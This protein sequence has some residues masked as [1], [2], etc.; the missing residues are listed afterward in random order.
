MTGS[1]LT[2]K[3]RLSQAIETYLSGESG[4]AL[5]NYGGETKSH[6]ETQG[7]IRE[8]QSNVG[9]EV[10]AAASIMEQAF[11]KSLGLQ[12]DFLDE[13]EE[14]GA[15]EDEPFAELNAEESTAL[16]A[17]AAMGNTQVTKADA[18]VRAEWHKLTNK[19]V[20][21]M[22]LNMLRGSLAKTF[23]TFPCFDAL[24]RSK[25]PQAADEINVVL[26]M[27]PSKT[28]NRTQLAQVANLPAVTMMMGLTNKKDDEVERIGRW[29][30]ANSFAVDASTMEFVGSGLPGYKP[31]VLM[32]LS[33]DETFILVEENSGIADYTFDA[34]TGDMTITAK[35][36]QTIQNGDLLTEFTVPA[37]GM[38][39][40]VRKNGR[41]ISSL[42]NISVQTKNRA[43]GSKTLSLYYTKKEPL[44]PGETVRD[45]LTPNFNNGSRLL[46]DVAKNHIP[47]TGVMDAGKGGNAPLD[48]KYIYKFPG[49]VRHYQKNP[50]DVTKLTKVFTAGNTI[51]VYLDNSD[52]QPKPQPVAIEHRQEVQVIPPVQQAVPEPVAA[53]EPIELKA[54]PVR[55]EP[56]PKPTP[57]PS[58]KPV[59]K[60]EAR[61]EKKSSGNMENLLLT[62]T[63]AGFKL[64]NH[65]VSENGQKMFSAVKQVGTDTIACIPTD[66]R[67]IS[68]SKEISVEKIGSGRE[69]LFTLSADMPV[70]DR[71]EKLASVLAEDT[72]YN[73]PKV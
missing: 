40:D 50:K 51:K 1:S 67:P 3:D 60:P 39:D 31:K 19:A 44:Q 8:I 54:V 71:K 61:V 42:G 35:G 41:V 36:D 72:G 29:V 33:Q 65:P 6:R 26:R 37:G 63:G 38:G 2:R 69:K 4:V 16:V 46:F 64:G 10:F 52:R 15:D 11:A 17:V 24:R 43:D 23:S 5:P 28:A 13:Q 34:E 48:A 56:A 59:T 14:P 27:E 70:E 53:P 7:M 45:A 47:P 18:Q 62:I 32:A 20:N 30:R 68:I 21:R 55:N 12:P 22:Q 25:G 57:K 73:P 66:G 58:S 49:G 9:P